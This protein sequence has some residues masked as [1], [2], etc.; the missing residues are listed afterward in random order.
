[1]EK[2]DNVEKIDSFIKMNDQSSIGTPAV[3]SPK[4]LK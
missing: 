1:M 2:L 3:V 4:S